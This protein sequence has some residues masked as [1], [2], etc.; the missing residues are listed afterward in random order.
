MPVGPTATSTPTPL[1]IP[2]PDI[3]LAL[4]KGVLDGAGTTFN[5]ALEWRYYELIKYYTYV[6]LYSGASFMIMN[7]GK[8][9]SLPKDIQ[10]QIMGDLIPQ[11]DMPRGFDNRSNFFFKQSRQ[12]RPA[13]GI[14]K[15]FGQK[16]SDQ[17]FVTIARLVESAGVIADGDT[18]TCFYGDIL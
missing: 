1:L 16:L 4:Q 5:A 6:P 18:V 17:D 11:T 8:W 2:I 14:H 13:A 12:P 7:L 9:N 15:P 3:Y 10:E